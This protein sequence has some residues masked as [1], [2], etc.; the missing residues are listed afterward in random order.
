M[1]TIERRSGKKMNSTDPSIGIV[2]PTY[3]MAATLAETI[4]SILSQNY[5][6]LDL[7]VVDGASNDETVTLLKGYGDQLRWISESDTGQTNAINKGMNALNC[8]IVKWV[9]ADD[10][11]LPGSLKTVADFFTQNPDIDF[12]YGDIEFINHQGKLLGRHY[13]PSFSKFILL[14]GH[15]LFAD[16]SCFW[17]QDVYKTI[18]L[19]DESFKYSMDYELWV[20]LVRAGKQFGQIKQALAQYRVEKGNASIAN[21][22]IMR[23]EHFDILSAHTHWLKRIP[24]TLRIMLFNILLVKARVLKRILSQIQRGKHQHFKFKKSIQQAQ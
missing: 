7:Y 1:I 19:F 9:N 15:N 21:Q 23:I 22:S 13:E 24:N 18:G 17:R 5:I 14:Y 2:I 12:L 10:R 6:N 4:D 11:L 8:D 3:N 16:P 20:K